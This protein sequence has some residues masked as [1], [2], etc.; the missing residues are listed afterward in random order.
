MENK[1]KL[2]NDV[3]KKLIEVQKVVYSCMLDDERCRKD[4]DYLYGKAIEKIAS[5]KGIPLSND[6][7]IVVKVF[8]DSN[9]PALLNYATVRRSRQ[10]IQELTPELRSNEQRKKELEEIHRLYYSQ[11]R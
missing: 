6:I 1:K 4:D 9:S 11:L 7:K 2:E 5:N 8:K 3:N 10:R